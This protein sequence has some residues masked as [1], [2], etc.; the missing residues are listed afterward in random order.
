MG[1]YGSLWGTMRVA[2]G[3]NGA[4][5][6]AMGHRVGGSGSQWGRMGRYGSQWGA[7]GPD[8]L[9]EAR[10]SVQQRRQQRPLQ[11]PHRTRE[12]Q[13]AAQGVR[14]QQAATGRGDARTRPLRGGFRQGHA[15]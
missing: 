5:W 7:M 8:L 1:P 3:R 10:L 15:H 4:V 9:D 14:Q 2:V 12:Q 13:P 11:E 6:V